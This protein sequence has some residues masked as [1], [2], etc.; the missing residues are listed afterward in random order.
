M[1]VLR[2]GVRRLY[3]LSLSACMVCFVLFLCLPVQA[4]QQRESFEQLFGCQAYPATLRDFPVYLEKHWSRVLKAEQDHPCLQRTTSCLQPVDAPQWL[5][6]AAKTPS[7]NETDLLRT[8]NAFFNK[9]SPAS[10]QENY[11]VADYWPTLAE[12]FSHR[13]GDCKAYTLAKYFALR[14]L[15]MPD[16]KLRIVLVYRKK[17]NTNHSVVAVDTARGIFIL[18]NSARPSDLILPQGKYRAQFIPLFM[19]NEKGRWTFNQDLKL[20][21]A[22]NSK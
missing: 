5:Y 9:F 1:E 2:T 16:D 15:G 14:A 18:D 4:A 22:G 13:S 6:L 10:D 19:F 8:V 20:L 3:P 21:D 17:N 11:G 7:M 12:F